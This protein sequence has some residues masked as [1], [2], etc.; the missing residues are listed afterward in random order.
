GAEGLNQKRDVRGAGKEL[1]EQ[2]D[3]FRGER[4]AL[5]RVTAKVTDAI[6]SSR[7]V[8]LG[9]FKGLLKGRAVVFG[10]EIGRP[11]PVV[12]RNRLVILNANDGRRPRLNG[13]QQQTA[14]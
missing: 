6:S 4:K 2:F 11:T 13:S 7:R 14:D 10:E 1:I 12:A 5:A 8:R 3:V 9:A